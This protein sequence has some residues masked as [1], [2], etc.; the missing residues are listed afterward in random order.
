MSTLTERYQR[1]SKM[2]MEDEEM[3]IAEEI[4]LQPPF[5]KEIDWYLKIHH[6]QQ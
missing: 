2:K 3:P 1:F 5:Q 6:V 4:L